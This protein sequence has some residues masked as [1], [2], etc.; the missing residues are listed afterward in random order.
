MVELGRVW[1]QEKKK[2][3]KVVIGGVP[4]AWHSYWDCDHNRIHLNPRESYK[5]DDVYMDCCIHETLHAVFPHL[6][7]QI[8]KERT[9]IVKRLLKAMGVQ[10]M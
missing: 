9:P 4:S 7:E 10:P 3:I 2:Y 8:V 1:D 6:S 5:S